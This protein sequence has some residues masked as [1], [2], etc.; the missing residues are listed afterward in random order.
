MAQ[1]QM[2]AGTGQSTPIPLGFCR[3]IADVVRR[4]LKDQDNTTTQATV[5]TKIPERVDVRE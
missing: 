5:P 3:V 2:V 1:A 4:I